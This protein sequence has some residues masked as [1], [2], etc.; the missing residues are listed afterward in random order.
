MSERDIIYTSYRDENVYDIKDMPYENIAATEELLD[1]A[2]KTTV[3]SDE[4]YELVDKYMTALEKLIELQERFNEHKDASEQLWNF[5]RHAA[6]WMEN[7]ARD[8]AKDII[9]LK[10]SISNEFDIDQLNLILNR[11]KFKDKQINC[12]NRQGDIY[13]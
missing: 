4:E 11:R 9:H 13:A 7:T 5:D 1:Q 10:E 3:K 2:S 8:E 12:K 6:V